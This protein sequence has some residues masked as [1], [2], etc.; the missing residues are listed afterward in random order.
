MQQ[1]QKEQVEQ[2]WNKFLSNEATPAEVDRLFEYIEVTGEEPVNWQFVQEGFASEAANA[3]KWVGMEDERKL[4]LLQSWRDE[5]RSA[6]KNVSR[7][8][9]HQLRRWSWAAAVVLVFF[10]GIFLWWQQRRPAGTTPGVLARTDIAPGKNGAIL[11]LADGRQVMLD[12]LGTAGVIASQNG[13]QVVLENGQL[14]Y[15]PTGSASTEM[16][17]NTMSTPRGRQFRLMLPDG[18][19]VWLNSA[20]S[21]RY[22]TVFAGKE[23]QVEVTGEAY[24]EVA[25]NAQMPFRVKVAG[26]A[27][28][29]VLGTQFNVNAYGNIQTLRTTLLEG[30]VRVQ[31]TFE[32]AGKG[33]VLKP[34]QQAVISAANAANTSGRQNMTVIDH[35]DTDKVLAWKKGL[36]NFDGVSLQEAMQQLE[37]WYD[38]E[39]VYENGIPEI[40]FGGEISRNVSLEGLLKMLAGADLSFRIEKDRKLI[41]TK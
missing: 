2:L 21:L 18:T 7:G 16:L 32:E 33:V 35:V 20:S 5:V 36:F 39:V 29:E 40:P 6:H 23:R 12:S 8:V 37:R 10:T 11:T 3:T 26:R 1:T 13:T 19:R 28:I 4:L 22:P 38:I 15:Q 27:A 34:G 9:V 14:A 30:S 17:F 31:D 25:E 41:I 24:F